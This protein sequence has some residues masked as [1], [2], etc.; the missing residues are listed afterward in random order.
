MEARACKGNKLL[1]MMSELTVKKKTEKNINEITM[2][3]VIKLQSLNLHKFNFQFLWLS[4]STK[5]EM[6]YQ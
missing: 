2:T 3:Y 6:N 1:C 5:F 4:I